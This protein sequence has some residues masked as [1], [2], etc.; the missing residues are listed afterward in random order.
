MTHV[1]HAHVAH[2]HAHDHMRMP[3]GERPVLDACA[4]Y[5]AEMERACVW[6]GGGGGGLA[7]TRCTRPHAAA[8]SRVS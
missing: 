8:R 7:S 6:S 3:D 1:A 2:A 5:R 4:A